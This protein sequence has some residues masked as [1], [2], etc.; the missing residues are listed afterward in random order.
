MNIVFLLLPFALFLA[1]GFVLSFIWCSKNGQYDDL[2]TPAYR[3]LLD[4]ERRR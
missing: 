1:L 3:I 4:E 2:E